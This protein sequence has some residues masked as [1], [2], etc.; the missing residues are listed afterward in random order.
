MVSFWQQTACLP[1]WKEE[2]IF[3]GKASSIGIDFL[4]TGENGF[5]LMIE[6]SQIDWAG[7]GNNVEYMITEMNDFEQTVRSVMDYAEKDGD[8]L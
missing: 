3:S 1:C 5:F 7:H 6:G 2:R 4:S 8:T